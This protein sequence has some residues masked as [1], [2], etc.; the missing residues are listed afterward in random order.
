MATRSKKDE[1]AAERAREADEAP[2]EAAEKPRP[3]RAKKEES[4]RSSLLGALS[5]GLDEIVPGL[6]ILDRELALEGARADL[7]AIDPAGR[8]HL[9]LLAAEG[10]RDALD[11]LD[12]LSFLRSHTDLLVRHL[13]DR[14]VDPERSPRVF[15][16]SPSSDARLVERLAPLQDSG[17]HVLGLSAVKSS[18]GERSYLVRLEPAARSAP[19]SSGVEAFLRALPTRLEPLG[20]ALVERMARLDEELEPS[21]DA[22]TIVWRL[23]GEVLARVERVG[24]V[25][26]A[27]VAPQHEPRGLAELAD[28]DR[29]TD[30]ALARLVQILGMTRPAPAP[31]PTPGP[32]DNDRE[33]LLTPEEIEAFRE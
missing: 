19:R 1:E 8:I 13:A 27:S 18:A 6:E 10:D 32:A 26:Q 28:L 30:L 9:V 2:D 17:V 20:R 16:I 22:T 29:L 7:A 5:A 15:V 24:D 12:T 11:V 31:R 4:E 3:A 25:F 21:A 33:P 23:A 14:R